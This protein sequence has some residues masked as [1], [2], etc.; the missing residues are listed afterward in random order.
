MKQLLL[1][2]RLFAALLL[3]AVSTLSWAYNFEVEGIYNNINEDD[4]S[5]TVTSKT[6][7]CSPSEIEDKAFSDKSKVYV[8]VPRDSSIAY[9]SSGF[10]EVNE[11]NEG[12]PLVTINLTEAGM[13]QDK[14]L[15]LDDTDIRRL[16]LS[17][18]IT[19]SDISY[20]RSSARFANL[21][22]LDISEIALVPSDEPYAEFSIG[23]KYG[24]GGTTGGSSARFY[25][26]EE[27][28]NELIY[29]ESNGLGG[30][31]RMYAYYSRNLAGA[32][33][34]MNLE[35]VILPPSFD[36]V[37]A[38]C[39]MK[40][41][42]LKEVSLPNNSEFK[43]ID[44]FAFTSCESLEE[45]FLPSSVIFIGA[46]A[47]YECKMLNNIGRLD[48]VKFLGKSS[49]AYC[50]S[51][52]NVGSL[53]SVEILDYG[54]SN[55]GV[56][57]FKG[58]TSLIGDIETG[59]LDLSSCNNIP[60]AR[61]YGDGIFSG[62]SSI[63]EV[64]FS[65]DLKSIG[66]YAF[67]ECTNI[68]IITLPDGLE[69][70]GT[71][72]FY[73]CSNLKTASIPNSLL[74]VGYDTFSNTPFEQTF[75]LDNG[76]WYM[77]D[78]A[79]SASSFS[80]I[81]F[82]EGT[83]SIADGFYNTMH[84]PYQSAQP[85]NC[86]SIT[87]PSTLNCIGEESFQ[88]VGITSL[89]LPESLN[90]IGANAFYDCTFLSGTLT[91]PEN[92]SFIGANAFANCSGLV[93][94][95]YN[96]NSRES[97]YSAFY[98][99]NGLEKVTIGPKVEVIPQ[100]AFKRSSIYKLVFTERTDATK[101]II[102]NQAFFEN[103][104][105]KEIILPN[106]TDSIGIQA[107]CSC[108]RLTSVTL[109]NSVTSIGNS[110]FNG[111]SGVKNVVCQAIKIPA[112][113]GNCFYGIA[114]SS[115]TLYVPKSSINVYKTTN[116][117]SSFGTIL[118]IDDGETSYNITVTANPASGGSITGAGT[119][120]DGTTVTLTATP[121]E[122]YEFEKWTENGAQVSTQATYTFTATQD[123][124]LV[125]NFHET[126]EGNRIN[127]IYYNIDTETN[128]AVVTS[129]ELKYTGDIVIPE[130]VTYLGNTYI[131]TSIGDSAFKECA[132]LTSVTIPSG[133]INI[134]F[135]AFRKCSKLTSI[136]IPNSVT[137][138]KDRAFQDCR[139]LT[140]I[141]IPNSVISIGLAAFFDTAWYNEQP[142]GL[143][144]AGKVAYIY[145]G[146][147]PGETHIT[148]D[149]GTLG[150]AGYAFN[151]CS[152]LT[153]V[154]IPN[155]VACIGDGAFGYCSNLTSVTC[156][157]EKVPSTGI[158]CFTSVPQS[159]AT[160]C[161]PSSSVNAY[162]SAFQW[163]SFGTILPIEDAEPYKPFST[164][165]AYYLY[166][167]EADLYL[168]PGNSWDTQASVGEAGMD[169]LFE[170]VAG[171][172]ECLYIGDTQC[173]AYAV[174]TQIYNSATAH[175]L[176]ISGDE[177][178]AYFDQEPAA[179]YFVPQ[180]DGTFLLSSNTTGNYLYY[181]GVHTALAITSDATQKGTKWNVMTREDII[182]K[183][184]TATEV[185]PVNVSSLIGYAD[186][187][188]NGKM[189]VGVWQGNPSRGGN[190]DNFCAE[191]FDCNFNVYQILTGLPNG[192]YKVKAQAY[193][194]EGADR[195][196][197]PIPAVELRKNGNEHLYAKLYANNEEKSVK[198]I[199]DEVDNC[200]IGYQTELGFVPNSVSSAA[201]TFLQGLY[202]NEL[203]TEV[204][205]GTL[206]LGI[207]KNEYVFY[208][209]T[210]FDSFRLYYYGK[211]TLSVPL[212]RLSMSTESTTFDVFDFC[213]HKVRTATN[214]LDDLP[215][216]V[217]IVGN[218]GHMRKVIVR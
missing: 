18:F 122:G 161:V 40:C 120:Q 156:Y 198:S 13:L 149:E 202:W 87:L 104:N 28:N 15:D 172:N 182:S 89:S 135:S 128:T 145:K 177:T 178:S 80:S 63:Q 126:D 101:L 180:E 190:N 140:T 72:A 27:E 185:E 68:S 71:S 201:T 206:Q 3:L 88:G 127:G 154:A 17:G 30:A 92:V 91:I 43:Y 103:N 47:F 52:R 159:S 174:N 181:D 147:M 65:K 100:D 8:T 110:A 184:E 86:K 73:S 90:Y 16:K 35:Y 200:T 199:F 6:T 26:S 69:K 131:V 21:K 194:R 62:C 176:G 7:D 37:G 82:R 112:T 22:F 102:G 31:N 20:L 119:Y 61:Y 83:R 217:Y 5:V 153:S 24:N 77:K 59:I 116:P 57:C 148:L 14:L 109:P 133:V 209:W 139:S 171:Q 70:I 143:V 78:I 19:A 123:R 49:F 84:A 212:E 9:F 46:G 211:D 125:A 23:S 95:N 187:S 138:I 50:E 141:I 118:P 134:G 34:G 75:E 108:K 208:D 107:F 85:E 74:H 165:M 173:A 99:C 210:C 96:A 136:N 142:N 144:Y 32:F 106:G 207:R 195:N 111:C 137:S 55:L 216:G 179:W 192:V 93:A 41:K 79:M 163:S 186:F 191:K 58:C 155:S 158:N 33:T 205:D 152:G 157:A 56:S 67:L 203:L 10:A 12:F 97:D 213:G 162:K 4:T 129:G 98:G 150:I 218:K 39:F 29:S 48:N 160:L 168:C 130:T 51:L 25:I 117:W 53:A 76:V 193:Y 169:L 124:T 115:S 215:M 132:N 2:K 11:N 64:K 146:T 105:I 188:R 114:M 196:Y 121:A 167:E 204:T 189:R 164:T 81:S 42:N 214:T 1:F 170:D 44:E 54:I 197:N 94:V 175:Y 66:S 166:N 36:R 151:N 45:I 38:F 113:D 60:E 183:M